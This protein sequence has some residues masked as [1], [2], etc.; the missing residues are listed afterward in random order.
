M[1]IA[2]E[3]LHAARPKKEFNK[4]SFLCVSSPAFN[5]KD[6]HEDSRGRK[7]SN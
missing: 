1:I 2:P 4:L 7:W 6:V 5:P 3:T